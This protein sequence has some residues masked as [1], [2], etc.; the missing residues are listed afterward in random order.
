MSGIFKNLVPSIWIPTIHSTGPYSGHGPLSAIRMHPAF[1]YLTKSPLFICNL[2]YLNNVTRILDLNL[3]F[4]SLSASEC[5]TSKSPESDC[6]QHSNPFC[7]G[8]IFVALLEHFFLFAFNVVNFKKSFDK[9]QVATSH[10]SNFV[11][12]VTSNNMV[13]I[14]KRS[15]GDG[16]DSSAASTSSEN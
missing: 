13:C 3:G 12:A 7:L 5:W 16:D 11:V 10:D 14:W 9:F 2:I 6:F 8:L 15:S 4:R 1:D